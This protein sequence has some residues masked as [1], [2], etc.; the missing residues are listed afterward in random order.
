M[1]KSWRSNV[2][3]H[4]Y[5]QCYCVTY[6]KVA[7]R[8]DFKMFSQQKINYMVEMLANAIVVLYCDI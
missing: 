1:N 7:N 2:Q 8:L 4:D 5:S 3:N 6:F